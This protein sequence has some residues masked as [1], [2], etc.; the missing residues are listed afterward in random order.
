M[1]IYEKKDFKEV[2][3]KSKKR[4]SRIGA[5]DENETIY[6]LEKEIYM[7]RKT[8][9]QLKNDLKERTTNTLKNDENLRILGCEIRQLPNITINIENMTNTFYPESFLKG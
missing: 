1:K 4:A 5:K 6:L 9:M 8:I 3:E 7:Y 2:V